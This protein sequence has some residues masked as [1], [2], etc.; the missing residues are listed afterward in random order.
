VKT[1]D[2]Q[3]FQRKEQVISSGACVPLQVDG[4]VLGVLNVNVM[5]EG[6]HF[7]DNELR[8]LMIYA[9][10]TAVAIRNAALRR[11]SEEKA[12]IR[13]ILEGYVSPEVAK[14]L[15]KDPKGWMNVGDMRDLTVLFAD[16]RGFT[17]AVHEMGPRET[18]LFLNQYFTRMSEVLFDH[19]GTLDKFIG[20]SVM[21]FFGAPLQVKT[22]GLIAVRAARAMLDAFGEIL[23]RWTEGNPHVASL[24]LGIGISTG[25]LFVG[26]VG[27]QK[28]FDY[29]AIGQE[30]NVAKRLC[31]MAL[32]GQILIS[33]H[34]R[35][36]LPPHVPVRHMG[37]VHFKGLERSVHVFEVVTPVPA[38]TAPDPPPS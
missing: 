11:D 26:N 18:R 13:S 22:P 29:T 6:R 17:Q 19:H 27:S 10:H 12:K 24:S 20:D 28:R 4:R 31:D 15:M 33:E 8:L 9:N 14:A 21:A 34:T 1:G 16:I 25:H 23:A 3:D 38:V 2:F 37:D 35:K 32:G 7:N 30:V 36:I 5:G